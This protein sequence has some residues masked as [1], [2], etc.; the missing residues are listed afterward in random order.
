M[1]RYINE[2]R[3]NIREDDAS[4]RNERETYSED[5]ATTPVAVAGSFHLLKCESSYLSEDVGCKII[6]KR[7]GAKVRLSDFYRSTKLN[8]S[9][10]VETT[11]SEQDSS[12]TYHWQVG[13]IS[14]TENSID[15]LSFTLDLVLSDGSKNTLSHSAPS[16]LE[17]SY[18]LLFSEKNENCEDTCNSRST[19]RF[20]ANLE[21]AMKLNR[22]K[23]LCVRALRSFGINTSLSDI[24]NI[25]DVL[26]Q[27]NNEAGCSAH[28]GGITGVNGG[29]NSNSVN[30]EFN[31]NNIRSVC[32]CK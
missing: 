21:A 23:L 32:V 22:S 14:P 27:G 5:E 30:L 3:G 1:F 25:P 13:F 9:T 2:F 20:K 7:D 28:Y 11:I 19:K 29:Y 12:A 16:K 10:D 26:G 17:S 8:A 15:N 6:D 18:E 24:K 31:N 4:Q